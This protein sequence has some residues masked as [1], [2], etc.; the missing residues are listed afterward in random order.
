V[1]IPEIKACYGEIV[2]ALN[3]G[4]AQFE[5][6]KKFRIVADELSPAN[7]TLTASLKLRRR[8]IEEL[9]RDHIETMYEE[10]EVVR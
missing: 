5:K 1:S 2:S 10:T 3:E 9:Y 4:L 8:V 7:G 6:L